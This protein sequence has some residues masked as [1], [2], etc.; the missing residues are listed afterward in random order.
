MLPDG[1]DALAGSALA[2]GIAVLRCFSARQ[3]QLSRKDLV[4]RTGLPKA[5]V[6]RLA[7]TLCALGLLRPAG[8][9]SFVLGADVLTFAPAILGRLS[10]RHVARAAMQELADRAQAQVTISAGTG[11]SLVFAEICQGRESRVSQPEIGTRLSL[12]RTASGRAYLLAEQAALR[13]G[14]LA[15]LGLD[16]A[17]QAAWLTRRLEETR[18]DLASHGFAH[19]VGDMHPDVMGA[20]IPVRAPAGLIL[21]F[22]CT[23]TAFQASEDQLMSD[24]GPR[25]M[26][27][28]KGVEAALPEQAATIDWSDAATRRRR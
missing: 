12:T 10:L 9:G 4:E 18:A 5:T 17:A 8:G 21:V 26:A 16:D 22:T 20:A 24:I 6:S 25:L 15:R 28:V 1:D 7:G 27:V 3:P 14:L 11:S 2:R 13:E 23:V 19:N